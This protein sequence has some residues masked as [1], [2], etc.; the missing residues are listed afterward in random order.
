MPTITKYVTHS[1]AIYAPKRSQSSQKH[2]NV[3]T[4]R[5]LKR[6]LGLGLSG[7]RVNLEILQALQKPNVVGIALYGPALE[8]LL[9][10]QPLLGHPLERRVLHDGR[11]LGALGIDEHVIVELVAKAE[12]VLL[13]DKVDVGPGEGVL[14]QGHVGLGEVEVVVVGQR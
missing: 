9:L 6:I 7:R 10:A 12:Y 8:I 14:A 3:L 13:V 4:I 1:T 2:H 11:K 5:R